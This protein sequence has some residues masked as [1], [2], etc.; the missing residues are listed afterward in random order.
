MIL[1]ALLLSL[2]NPITPL[3][4]LIPIVAIPL[5]YAVPMSVGA[6]M[7]RYKGDGRAVAINL[8]SDQRMALIA[9][10]VGAIIGVGPLLGFGITMIMTG[11]QIFSLSAQALVTLGMV[12]MAH[13]QIPKLL[14]D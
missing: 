8:A 11:S 1:V 12:L 5:G 6:A 4:I 3:V 13:F 2:F 14:K 9:G 7:Y 10:F